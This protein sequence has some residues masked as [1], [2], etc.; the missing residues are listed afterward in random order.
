M[1]IL[2]VALAYAS[3]RMLRQRPNVFTVIFLV[4]FLVVLLGSGV[5][6]PYLTDWIRPWILQVPALAGTRGLLLGIGLG[7]IGAGLRVLTGSD[8]PYGGQH[9]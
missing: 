5:E 7:A 6:V 4:T 2:A 9:G 3:I 8:H 1:A